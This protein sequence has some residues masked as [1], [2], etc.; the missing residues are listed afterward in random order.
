MRI[1]LFGGTGFVGLALA[2][3][4]L[5]LGHE[6]VLFDRAPVPERAEA[7]FKALPGRWRA[8]QGEI[9]DIAAI[10]DA[11]PP[12]TDAVVLGVAITADA[13]RDAREPARVLSVNLQGQIPVLERARDVGVK[14]I[15]N[16]SSATVYGQNSFGPAPLSEEQAVDPVGLYPVSK[17][18]SE[19]T[20]RRLAALWGLDHVNVRLSAAYGLWERATGARDTM[21]PLFQILEAAEA[22]RPALLARPGLRDWLFDG[23]LA[24]ALLTVVQAP[25]PPHRLYNISSPDSFTALAFGQALQALCPGF[26][27]RLCAPGETPTIDLHSERDRAPL[28]V[29]R[30]NDDFGWQAGT[31]MA[32]AVERLVAVRRTG[33]RVETGAVS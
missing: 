14:R 26:V 23:D 27:C 7:V 20:G 28:S 21:S 24:E 17:L 8:V 4:A 10:S 32:M 31:T 2:E 16:L 29:M 9:E 12:G 30:M 1:S 19:L 33:G 13:A 3:K 25:A 6:V 5:T 18:A 11:V 22:G 15:V